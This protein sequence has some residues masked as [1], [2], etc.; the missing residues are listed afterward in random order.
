MEGY[1]FWF[2]Q[3]VHTSHV[4]TRPTYALIICWAC[5]FHTS[6][7]EDLK[8]TYYILPSH[9]RLPMIAI[10]LYEVHDYSKKCRSFRIRPAVTPTLTG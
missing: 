1:G 6:F 2:L 7:I 3:Y 8:D 4:L 5:L 9:L 10:L